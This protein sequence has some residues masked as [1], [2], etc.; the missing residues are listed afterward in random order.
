MLWTNSLVLLID[1]NQDQTDRVYLGHRLSQGSLLNQLQTVSLNWLS[2]SHR[3]EQPYQLTAPT[4]NL[5]TLKSGPTTTTRA[6]RT[7]SR[8][9]DSSA[10]KKP[11]NVVHSP[12]KPTSL[13]RRKLSQPQLGP[14]PIQIQCITCKQTDVPLILGGREHMPPSLLY[15][16]LSIYKV[17]VGPAL[18]LAKESIPLS[19]TRSPHMCLQV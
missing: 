15:T 9:T 14:V 7:T 8:K 3:A 11:D 18:S 6:K 4:F 5:K 1:Q 19:L 12:S 13:K 17:I 10:S 2:L 16:S